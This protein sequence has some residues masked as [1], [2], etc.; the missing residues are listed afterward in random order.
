MSGDLFRVLGNMA[1]EGAGDWL[2]SLGLKVVG[3]LL[4]RWGDL[5]GEFRGEGEVDRFVCSD[6][7]AI[8]DCS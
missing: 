3:F 6:V 2:G 7:A 1:C 8:L 5:L 4:W